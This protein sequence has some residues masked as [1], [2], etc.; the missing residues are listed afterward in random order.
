MKRSLIL[1]MLLAFAAIGMVEAGQYRIA[2]PSHQRKRQP[3]RNYRESRLDI[4]NDDDRG[5]AVDVDYRRNRLELQPRASGDVFIPGNSRVS[6]LFD[7]D[8][9]WRIDGDEGSLDIEIRA[10]G[11]TTLR[12]ETRA[13]RHQIGLF[14][15]VDDGRRVRSKQLFK[16]AERPGRSKNHPAPVV[17][18]TPPPVVVQ[19]PPPVV[20]KTPPPVVVRTPPPPPPPVVVTTPPPPPVVVYTPPPVVV[21]QRMQPPPPQPKPTLGDAVGGLID[22]VVSGD[23]PKR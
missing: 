13:N 5:Y 2:P 15:T 10:G 19:T 4:V 7:D 14:G 1:V 21:Q 3:P 17:V 18:H 20:V 9:N 16:Y 22:S 12:L 6:L 11:V 23:R 8:D